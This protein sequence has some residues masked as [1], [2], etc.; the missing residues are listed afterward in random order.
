[1]ILIIL[2]HTKRVYLQISIIIYK[3]D[4]IDCFHAKKRKNVRKLEKNK[5]N[6]MENKKLKEKTKFV[7]LEKKKE[8]VEREMRLFQVVFW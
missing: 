7:H 1:M 6:T 8:K 5:K 4:N 3:I 2:S